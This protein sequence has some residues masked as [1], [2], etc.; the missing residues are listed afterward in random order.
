MIDLIRQLAVPSNMMRAASLG[1]LPLPAVE[2][3]EIL[4]H[5]TGNPVFAEQARMTLAGWDEE[6]SV[7]AAADP[8]TPRPVLDY[9]MAPENWRPH[10]LPALLENPAVPESQ[11]LEMAQAAAREIVEIMLASPRV[12][13][14]VNVLHALSSN[15]YLRDEELERL[16][17]TLH[18]LGE[19]VSGP[20][21]DD[22]KSQYEVEHAEEIAAEE[23]KPFQLVGDILDLGFG[24]ED[25]AQ[26]PAAGAAVTLTTVANALELQAAEVPDDPQ[27]RERI[28]ALLRIARLSVGERVQ[29]AMKGNREERFI[30]I[31]DGVRVVSSA[32]LESPKLAE[33]EVE[34]FASMKNVPD[35]V[36]RSIATKRKFIKMYGV[37]KALTNNPRTPIDVGLPLLNHLFINDLRALSLNKN[38]SDTIRKLAVKMYKQKIISKH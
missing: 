5:L 26:A 4:V 20:G 2:M 35:S 25:F 27:V 12:N 29:L 14:S 11:L 30:L 36:L 16:R 10:L 21:E 7:A 3:I 38:V 28:S 31:R 1:A 18:E 6:S 13:K 34:L 33:N 8:D 24:D 32:V 37:I 9:F 15:Q 23:G 17:A 22:G 19:S